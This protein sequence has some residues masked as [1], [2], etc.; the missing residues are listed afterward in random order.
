M[1]VFLIFI[2][3]QLL[4]WRN[5]HLLMGKFKFMCMYGLMFS[6]IWNCANI[7]LIRD[8]IFRYYVWNHDW[9]SSFYY[10]YRNMNSSS[11]EHSHM[12][13]SFVWFTITKKKLP[14]MTTVKCMWHQK[15]IGEMIVMFKNCMS[16]CK[17]LLMFQII[18]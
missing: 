6:V 1:S 17:A 9:W 8:R 14:N 10:L 15:Y 11:I 18:F 5:L 4:M 7:I 16:C 13:W 12:L 3:Y 2:T